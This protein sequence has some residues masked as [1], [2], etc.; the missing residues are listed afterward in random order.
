MGD[1]LSEM[2]VTI[3]TVLLDDLANDV[4]G[5]SQENFPLQQRLDMLVFSHHLQQV[6]VH[7]L[8]R[9]REQAQLAVD[10]AE[11]A[12]VNATSVEEFL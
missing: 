12:H 1:S 2:K 9:L 8:L 4:L 7:I 10:L 5:G 11:V 3:A 6:N